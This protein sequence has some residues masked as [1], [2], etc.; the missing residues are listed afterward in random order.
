[1][2]ACLTEHV[3]S[4]GEKKNSTPALSSFRKKE[5]RWEEHPTLLFFAATCI[6]KRYWDSKARSVGAGRQRTVPRS[7]SWFIP[8]R[9]MAWKNT[10]PSFFS[11]SVHVL[12]TQLVMKNAARSGRPHQPM[13]SRIGASK[14]SRGTSMRWE[15]AARMRSGADDGANEAAATWNRGKSFSPSPA[16]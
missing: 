12:D 11:T 14:P 16:A 15:A 5:K 7:Q 9:R 6:G 8:K 2:R 10:K 4:R 13:N 3:W 1:M